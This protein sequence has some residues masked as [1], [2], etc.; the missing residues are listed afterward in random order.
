M[1]NIG[2]IGGPA[3]GAGAIDGG[4]TRTAAAPLRPFLEVLQEGR[5][6]A[7]AGATPL[8]SAAPQDRRDAHAPAPATGRGPGAGA[9]ASHPANLKSIAQGAM[10]VERELDRVLAAAAGG[11]TFSPDELLQLQAKVF[12]Y[13]QTVE[14]LSRGT[15]RL[16]GGVKQLLQ[17]Q[18]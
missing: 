10:R 1:T 2:K 7:A 15:D 6:S 8:A 14:I 11:K 5:R 12:R 13:S 18:G 16:L 17:Q 9:G 4:T 3:P